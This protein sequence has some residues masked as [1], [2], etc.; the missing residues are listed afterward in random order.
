MSAS[1]FAHLLRPE[2]IEIEAYVPHTGT[3]DIRL[4]G[5]EAPPL[6]SLEARKK[7]QEALLPPALERYPDPRSL[8]L[9]NAIATYIGAETNEVLAGMGSD[10]VIALLLSALD[11]PR[12]KA[13]N[14]TIICPTPTFVMYRLSAK[15]RGMRVIEVPLDA[16]WDLDVS[17]MC[18]AIEFGQPN[19]IFLATPNNPTGGLMSE[20]RLRV[21]IEAAKDS[22]VVL[23]EA[24]SAFAKASVAHLRRVYPNVVTLGTLSKVGFASLRVGWLVG[25]EDLV[26]EIDKVRQPYNLPTPSQRAATLVLRDL[27]DEIKTVVAGVI[28]ERTR[29]SEELIR[30]G[31]GVTPSEANFVWVETKRPAI[32]VFEGLAESG[33]LVRSFHA[34]G[35]RLSNRLRI[36]IGTSSE[37]TRLLETIKRWA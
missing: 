29:V 16:Q 25:P 7:I 36:S 21:V 15:A 24:Y 23:D 20:D 2:L 26:A 19:L 1:R 4:D 34:R 27:R 18:K 13:K 35:G 31:F 12:G 11:N 14:A 3:Y 22:V 30:L 9:R 17:A 28:A 6:I 5:N 32:E 8:D 10:E 37:N 33:I